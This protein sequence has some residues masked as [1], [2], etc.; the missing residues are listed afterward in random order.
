MPVN[1]LFQ[2][3]GEALAVLATVDE[4]KEAYAADTGVIWV[5]MVGRTPESDAVLR[6]VFGFHELAIEDVYK[7]HHRPKVEDYDDYLYLIVEGLAEGWTL[8]EVETFEVDI[9]VGKNFIVTHHGGELEVKGTRESIVEGKSDALTKGAAYVAHAI[10]DKVVDRI[11]PLGDR[12]MNMIDGIEANVLAGED[13]LAKIVALTGGLQTL[14]RMIALQRDVV[15]RLARAEFDEIP[16]SS[17]PFFRDVHEHLAQLAD[18]LDVQ[19]DELNA[20]F[21]AFHSLSAHRMNEIMR[22]LTLVSTVM[23]PLSFLAGVYGMNFDNM[24]ETKTENG[25]F[26]LWGV[27]IAITGGMLFYFR[28]RRWL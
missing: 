26:V 23:L 1:I 6:D 14:R 25:Y 12:Y 28:K 16:E 15:A 7:E 18:A 11:R 24:P 17:K 9:F 5:D 2:K 20:V 10:I 4:V 13:E 22:V 19:R 21:N 8:Q 3:P 27:M